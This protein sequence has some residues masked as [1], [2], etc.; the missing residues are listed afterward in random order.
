VPGF[1]EELDVYVDGGELRADHAF[2]VFGLPFLVLRY[3]IAPK[4]E[5]TPG[6]AQGAAS[7]AAPEATLEAT[8]EATPDPR[9]DPAPRI[10]PEQGFRAGGRG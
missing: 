6:A 1:A 5:A 3:R 7:E 10:A 9:T 2:W 8:T 4:P